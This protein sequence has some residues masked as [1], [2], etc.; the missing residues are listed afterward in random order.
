MLAA[1]LKRSLK[2]AE[3]L[4]FRLRVIPAVFSRD[5]VSFLSEDAGCLRSFG[6]HFVHSK[7]L[8][9]ILSQAWLA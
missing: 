1:M 7:S 3:P 6:L 2:G 8:P 4:L 5:P 9:A